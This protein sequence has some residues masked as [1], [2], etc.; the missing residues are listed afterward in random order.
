MTGM[1]VLF[2]TVRVCSQL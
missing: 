2:S 1:G